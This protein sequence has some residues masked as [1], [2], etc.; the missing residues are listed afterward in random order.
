MRPLAYL[1]LLWGK[2]SS[3]Q[4][5]DG[6]GGSACSDYLRDNLHKFIVS[7]SAFPD[8][9]PRAIQNGFMK[10]DEEFLRQACSRPCEIEVSGTCANILFV[11]DDKGYVGN[12]GD[13]RSVMSLNK[14]AKVQD[15]SNDHKPNYPPERARI[16]TS[17]GSV[18]KYK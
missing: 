18:Y 1:L 11:V 14:G 7:D 15:L 17:G 8:D 13:S 10:A 4:V 16:E 12:S 3:L 9:V 2:L 5:F 6:H